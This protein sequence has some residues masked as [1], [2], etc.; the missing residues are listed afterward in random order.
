[1]KNLTTLL[2]LLL[3]SFSWAEDKLNLTCVTEIP[4]TS[5]FVKDN[6]ESVSVEMF[7]HNGTSYMPIFDGLATPNDLRLLKQKAKVLSSLG[8][9]L[10][11]NW[12]RAKCTEQED[13]VQQCFGSTEV[14]KING[15]NVKAWSFNSSLVME[16]TAMG[17]FN[18]YKLILNLDVDGN[19]YYI[20]MKYSEN[21]C[22][23][24]AMRKTPLNE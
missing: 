9:N 14:Q 13:L 4:T 11:F 18:S 2:L 16:K 6:G 8:N 24:Q 20:P 22:T 12:P 7:N 10:H 15:H 1:M 5:F 23:D 17:K 19:S 3:P 21:E